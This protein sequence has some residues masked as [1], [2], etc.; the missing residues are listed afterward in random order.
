MTKNPTK[1]LFICSANSA[2]SQMAEALLK[3]R[4]G[5]DFEVH[6]AGL[7]S[8]GVHPMTVRV[9]SEIGIDW[10]EAESTRLESLIGHVYFDHA[11]IVCAAAAERCPR[12]YPSA[13]EVL[14]WPFDDPAAAAGDDE[15]KIETFRR[16]RDEIDKRL[17]AW[18]DELRS[19]TDPRGPSARDMIGR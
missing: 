19:A 6:S 8:T 5:D 18:L 1:V 14:K 17:R 3:W 4:A 9:L 7:E 13:R 15:A 10:S 11:I 12:L 16:V 2:R